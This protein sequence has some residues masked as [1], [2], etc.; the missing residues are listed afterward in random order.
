MTELIEWF[1]KSD[2]SGKG[3]RISP[4]TAPALL[5]ERKIKKE[6]LI[7]FSEIESLVLSFMVA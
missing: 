2:Y 1:Y 3:R 4:S 5:D 7:F 6:S